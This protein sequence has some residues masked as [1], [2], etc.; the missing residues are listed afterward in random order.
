MKQNPPARCCEDGK[1]S[2][3]FMLSSPRLTFDKIPWAPSLFSPAI[4][5][6]AFS[7][8][9]HV[10]TTVRPRLPQS[11]INNLR[12][13]MTKNPSTRTNTFL[14]VLPYSPRDGSTTRFNRSAGRARQPTPG[15][16]R[17]SLRATLQPA[18][19]EFSQMPLA[20][21]VVPMAL[22]K[23]SRR[24]PAIPIRSHPVTVR[25]A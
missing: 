3:E 4:P 8:L 24:N 23:F 22:P 10:Q 20:S 6:S 7:R 11:P 1:R 19:T 13:P 18:V 17:H 21:P 25:H 14:P 2:V 12:S 16:A 9:C 5:R 15:R